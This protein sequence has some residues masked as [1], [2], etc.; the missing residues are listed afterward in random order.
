MSPLPSARRPAQ[1]LWRSDDMKS[2][3][4]NPRFSKLSSQSK[5]MGSE[6]MQLSVEDVIDTK[7]DRVS[8]EQTTLK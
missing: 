1:F 4:Y 2:L 3:L 5:R 7:F 8:D 6:S